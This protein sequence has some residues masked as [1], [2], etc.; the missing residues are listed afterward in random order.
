MLHICCNTCGGTLELLE[1]QAFAICQS[2]GQKVAVPQGYTKE[3]SRFLAASHARQRHDFEEAAGIYQEILR[4]DPENT[5]A[6]W[7]SAL[8]RFR[9][10]YQQIGEKEYRL[11]C[12]RAS[13]GAFLDDPDYKRA[14]SL[15]PPQEADLYREEA[16]KIQDLQERITR[17]LA[18]TQPWDV[19]VAASEVSLQAGRRVVRAL[20]EEGYRVFFPA[21]FLKGLPRQDWE[22]DLFCA[23]GTAKS[24]VLVADRKD[25]FTPDTCFDA[26]RF[27]LRGD[28]P[29]YIAFGRLEEYED[30]PGELFDG[31]AAR[32]NM[33]GLN[34]FDS[35]LDTLEGRDSGD[36]YWE[37]AGKTENFAY[38]NL[39]KSAR[40]ELEAGNFSEARRL[41]DQVLDYNPQEA[42][43]YWGLLLVSR[44]CRDEKELEERGELVENDPH[45]TSALAFATPREQQLWQQ[46]AQNALERARIAQ[47]E[48]EERRREEEKAERAKQEREEFLRQ[49]QI[50]DQ[51]E[52]ER[53]AARHRSATITAAALVLLAL[54]GGGVF[55]F[56]QWKTA[57]AGSQAYEEA[58]TAY[59]NREYAAAQNLFESLGDYKDSREMV[60]S[61]RQ[62][63]ARITYQ[64]ALNA[65]NRPGAI[66]DLLAITDLVP[67]AQGT[68]DQWRQEG[69]D[70]YAAGQWASA[71]EKLRGFGEDTPEMLDL[72]RR[73]ADSRLLAFSSL[74]DDSYWAFGVGRDGVLYRAGSVPELPDGAYKSVSMS[75][76]K[77]SAGGVYQDGTAVLAGM[78]AQAADVSGW[79]GCT[80]IMVSDSGA[81][82]LRDDGTLLTTFGVEAPLSGVRQADY[83]NGGLILCYQDG[84][85]WTDIPECQGDVSQWGNL[86]WVAAGQHQCAAVTADGQLLLSGTGPKSFP[87]ED[88]L[89]ACFQGDYMAV[90]TTDNVIHYGSDGTSTCSGGSIMAV[91]SAEV[92]FSGNGGAVEFV[93]RTAGSTQ[94]GDLKKQLKEWGAVFWPKE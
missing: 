30:I 7:G 1:G 29:L 58:M 21:D 77:S 79:T 33:D 94:K 92:L 51:Q 84:T 12:H 40:L 89:W 56:F 41:F 64:E 27:L 31:A 90:V 52:K 72:R 24:M 62:R 47:Q 2:C 9:V 13:L 28:A 67:E 85:A 50:K 75:W 80:N 20:E 57:S 44:Q 43:A 45:Y 86:V 71:Y 19:F 81:A 91:H 5:G 46:T 60:Q 49:A 6:L 53:R 82:S 4:G 66:A 55:L 18:G 78:A 42:Q 25:A 3:E 74:G 35:L 36:E 69:L 63:L 73:L 34:F 93:F 22:P 38:A 32:L 76:G 87:T 26:R 10:E 61:S 37:E 65:E 15:A 83:N 16:G 59:N 23:V 54:V 88:V 39:L 14:I 70:V 17:K 68:L 48:E 8:S 11:V